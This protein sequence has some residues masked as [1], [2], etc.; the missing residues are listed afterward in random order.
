MSDHWLSMLS[1]LIA[2]LLAR[3]DFVAAVVNWDEIRVMHTWNAIPANWE[4]LGNTT[5]GA[6][7]NLHIEIQPNRESALIDTLF[8]VSNPTHPRHVLAT[9]TLAPLFT[10]VAPF[11]IW[12]ISF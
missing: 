4:S 11:Q 10:C 9:P 6:R 8:E 1:F 2:L 12:S 7:I 3:A 5:D